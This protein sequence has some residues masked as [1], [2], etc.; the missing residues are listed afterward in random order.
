MKR[1]LDYDAFTG[2][3]TWHEYDEMTGETMLHYEQDVEDILDDNKA[4]ANDY[5][6][7]NLGEMAH[8]ASIPA[9]VQLKWLFEKG[10]DVH[11]PGHR[12][13]VAKL[14]DDSEWRHLKR[15]PIQIGNYS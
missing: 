10:V 8:V 6:K 13:A 7:G 2:L 9:S 1:L 11:N 5:S 15:L 4:S 14:L 12:G 3:I